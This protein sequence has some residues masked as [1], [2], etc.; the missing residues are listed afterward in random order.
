MIQNRI[1]SMQS[2][3]VVPIISMWTHFALE[4]FGI[5]MHDGSVHGIHEEVRLWVHIDKV[6]WTRHCPPGP[7]GVIACHSRSFFSVVGSPS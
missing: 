6:S 3:F 1:N 4:A 5:M 7:W 2:I